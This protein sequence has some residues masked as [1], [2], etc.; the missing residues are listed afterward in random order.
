[1]ADNTLVQMG[2]AD[3][4]RYPKRHQVNQLLATPPTSTG[5]FRLRRNLIITMILF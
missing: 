4:I 5:A 3:A 1:M 2:N